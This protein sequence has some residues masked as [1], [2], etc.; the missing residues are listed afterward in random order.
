M[1][2][3]APDID[4]AK[5]LMKL[6]DDWRFA[7]DGPARAAI[8]QDILKNHAENVWTIGLIGGVLQPVVARPNLVNMPAEGIYNWEPGAHFGIYRP[9]T[10]WL[11][12]G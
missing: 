9:D 5:A 1:A 10:W 4:P 2:G 12:E 7:E 6:F 11:K 3:E 8:W